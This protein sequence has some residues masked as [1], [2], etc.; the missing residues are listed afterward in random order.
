MSLGKALQ[1]PSL[2]HVKPRKDM[3]NVSCRCD[4]TNTVESGVK[5]YSINIEQTPRHESTLT[6]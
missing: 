4:M 3:N 6:L 2:V 1:S 5:H